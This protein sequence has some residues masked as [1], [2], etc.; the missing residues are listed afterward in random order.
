MVTLRKFTDANRVRELTNER[1]KKAFEQKTFN[2]RSVSVEFENVQVEEKDFSI[3]EQKE[4]LLNNKNL[5]N[6]VRGT[7]VLKDKKDGTVLDKKEL[8]LGK[9]PWRT[10]RNTYISKGNEYSVSNQFRLKYGVYARKKANDELE[11]HFNI[12]PGT[13]RSFR[14]LLEPKTGIFRLIVGQAKPY[15]Y[16][17]LRFAGVPD[18]YLEKHWGKEILAINKAKGGAPDVDKIYSRLAGYRA[19]SGLST[20]EKAQQ[21]IKIFNKMSMDARVNQSTMNMPINHINMGLILRVTKKLL[22][23]NKGVEEPDDRDSLEFR[24]LY[25][26]EDFFS[27]RIDKDAGKAGQKLAKRLDRKRKLDK[28]PSGYFTKALTGFVVEDDKSATGEQLNPLE[29][30][31]GALKTTP[32][33]EGGLSARN[34]TDELPNVHPSHLGFLDAIRVPESEK[35]GLTLYITHNTLKGDDGN[36]YLEVLD[37]KKNKKVHVNS[38]DFH[39]KTIAFPGEWDTDKPAIKV[40][41]NKKMAHVPRKKVDYALMSAAEMFT[42][43]TNLI[44]FA[45]TAQGNR[46]MMAAKM[47]PQALPLRDP[48]EALV[49]SKVPGKDMSFD[50]LYGK[51]TST[52]YSKWVGVVMAVTEDYIDIKET[53]TGETHRV[54]I[55]NNF[56]FNRKTS[57]HHTPIVTVGDKVQKG[58]VLAR[59]NYTNDKGSLALGKNLKTAYISFKGYNFEDGIVISETASKKMTSEHTYSYEV[60]KDDSITTGKSDFVSYFP[61]EYTVDDTAHLSAAGIAKK[62]TIVKHGQPL[63]LAMRKRAPTATDISLGNIHKIF[64]NTFK[65]VSEIWDHHGDGEVI[66]SVVAPGFLKVVVKSF[67]PMIVGDKIAGRHGNKGVVTKILPDSQM[68]HDG[69]GEPYEILLNPQGIITR[70]NPSQ[71]HETLLAKATKKAGKNRTLVENFSR[72]NALDFTKNKLKEAGVKDTDELYDPETNKKLGDILGGYQYFIKTSSTAEKG[73]NVRGYGGGYTSNAQPTKGLSFGTME[74]NALVAHN[75]RKIMRDAVTRK[76]QRN[77]EFWKALRAGDPLPPPQVPYIHT[78]FIDSLKSAGINVRKEGTR[79]KALP[80]TDKDV[81]ELSKGKVKHDKFLRAQDYKPEAGGLFDEGLTGGVLGKN[82]THIDLA[83]PLPN[84]V[85]EDSIRT[86]LDLTAKKLNNIVI[87]KDTLNGKTGGEAI[88]DALKKIDINKEIE[89]QLKLAQGS[90]KVARD[91]AIKKLRVLYGVRNTGVKPEDYI[92]TKVAVIPPIHRPISPSAGSGPDIVADANYLYR[93]LIMSNN[94]ITETLSLGLDDDDEDLQAAREHQ[95]TAMKKLFG[96]QAPDVTKGEKPVKGFIQQIVG[97]SPKFGMFQAKLLKKRQD[98]TGRAVITPDPN[99]GIDQM[100]MPKDMAWE[101][102]SPFVMKSLVRLGYR[103]IEAERMIKD[104]TE[105]AH[106]VLIKEMSERPA[107]VNRNP[108]L[109]KFN[110]MALYPQLTDDKVLTLPPLIEGGF[111]ADHDGDAMNVHIPISDDALEEAKE[112]MLPSKNLFSSRRKTAGWTPEQEAVIGLY[113]ATT[114]TGNKVV[115]TFNTAA[116]A[117]KAY[118]EGKISINDLIE[119][120]NLS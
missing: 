32:L 75:A 116:E 120:K 22:D 68:P 113:R 57:I 48:E 2:G 25:S 92:L 61:N 86:L 5:T 64:K 63:I 45:H 29:I 83:A 34:V 46:L 70:I 89:T 77:D 12:Q 98:L 39:S 51:Q 94:D 27:E 18:S 60:E 110:V 100:G 47:Q 43:S 71:I 117:K 11:G 72:G 36:L 17:V 23:I 19:E 40:M 80:M 24:K 10:P 41:Q 106:R 119:V 38:Q 33:G 66:E 90:R 115:K 93:D 85:M 13:G 54:E 26:A 96:L 73:F 58:T 105:Q 76:G 44:P 111:N 69:E 4:A 104:R 99:L 79:F 52:A 59:S 62:G 14:I 31:E 55:Y 91:K 9:L 114:P 28:I 109:H 42:T 50:D 103:P 21:V 3:K 88:R 78:K 53:R 37:V 7:M 16:P 118:H 74:L 15:L 49:Q 56:P 35:A 20:K 67:Q 6:R 81:M 101:L 107:L 84:P 112:K 102:Y 97:T 30:L 82:W 108:S 8:T 95:Y 87:G 1:L 65:N